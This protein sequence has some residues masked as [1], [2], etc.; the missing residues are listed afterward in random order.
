MSPTSRSRPIG[1]PGRPFWAALAGVCLLVFLLS[2]LLRGAVLT[3]VVL[4]ALAV[5]LGLS[6]WGIYRLLDRAGNGI[7]SRPVTAGAAVALLS[8]LY[9]VLVEG[10]VGGGMAA[11]VASLFAGIAAGVAL[12]LDER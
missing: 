8:L 1:P 3:G 2:V 6:A 7:D 11:L 9:A 5:P 12:D 10:V 4:A